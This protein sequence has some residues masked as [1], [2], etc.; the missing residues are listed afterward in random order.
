[1]IPFLFPFSRDYFFPLVA[2][3]KIGNHLVIF[4][5]MYKK[6]KKKKN[7]IACLRF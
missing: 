1:M 2:L 6:K 5:Q 7:H 4:F 3:D